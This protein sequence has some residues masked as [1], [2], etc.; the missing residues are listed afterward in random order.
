M[1][2]RSC[3]VIWLC[4]DL[5]TLNLYA[6]G[7]LKRQQSNF[8]FFFFFFCRRSRSLGTYFGTPHAKIVSKSNELILYVFHTKFCTYVPI[9]PQRHL[10]LIEI[11]F[12]PTTY[13]DSKDLQQLFISYSINDEIAN[14]IATCNEHFSFKVSVKILSFKYVRGLNHP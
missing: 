5:Q 8:S 2:P 13:F 3:Y 4:C 6:V 11:H 7:I 10:S 12:S 14:L 1:K 9:E